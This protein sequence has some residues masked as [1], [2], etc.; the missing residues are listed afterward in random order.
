MKKLIITLL[1]LGI[2]AGAG[3]FLHE[4]AVPKSE[5]L[6]GKYK[7]FT[8]SLDQSRYA[9]DLSYRERMDRELQERQEALAV[10]YINDRKPDEAIMVLET[11]I[12]SANGP[13]YEHGSRVLS[14]SVQTSLVADYYKMLSDAYDMKHDR[15]GKEQ[16]LKMSMHYRAEAESL[17]KRE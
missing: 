15:N 3:Y 9:T 17:R 1:V 13:R 10:A 12:D 14:N 4:G 7:K 2:I 6:F 11:L 8:A 16:A 5:R